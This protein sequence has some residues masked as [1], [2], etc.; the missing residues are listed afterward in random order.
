MYKLYRPFFEERLA[1]WAEAFPIEYKQLRLKYNH[2]NWGSCSTRG[3]INLST[4]LLLCPL[5][6]IDYVI[7]HE[8]AHLIQPN[9]SKA[10]WA[11]VAEVMPDWKTHAQWLKTEGTYLDF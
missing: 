1:Y 3:N 10:F 9:H 2:S 4:R 6:V 8:L 5:P 11:E 7:V